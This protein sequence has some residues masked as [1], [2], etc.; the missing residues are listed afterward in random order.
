M[1]VF[2]AGDVELDRCLFCRGLW[3]DGGE[4]DQ[5]LGRT[6]RPEPMAGTTN[7]KCAAC[8]TGMATAMLGGLPV[9][10]CP[11]CKG[12]FLDK[13]ELQTINGGQVKIQQKVHAVVTFDC[14]GCG[15][16]FPL[17]Q[18]ARVDAGLACAACRPKLEAKK[19]ESK[20]ETSAEL[21]SVTD[22]FK[23]IGL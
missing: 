1:Q 14:V 19:L 9:E 2:H 21:D 17:D 13:G 4:L 18:G 5:V 23:Q 10:T 8:K 3:F 16:A 12:I 7:R 15:G 22:W 11:T 6:L 20:A